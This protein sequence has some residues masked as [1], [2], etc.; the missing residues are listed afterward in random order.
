MEVEEKVKECDGVITTL[1]SQANQE[2]TAIDSTFM[3]D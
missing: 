1:Q 2:Q 3:I